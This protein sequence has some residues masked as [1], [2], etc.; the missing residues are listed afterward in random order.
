MI[1]LDFF[2]W[3]Y[4]AAPKKLLKIWGNFL[5]FF[6]LY[7]I[8]VPLL[9]KT[10]FAPWKRDIIRYGR[11]FEIKK[12]LEIFSLNIA[13]RVFG[14]VFRIFVIAFALL[15]ELVTVAG[16]F[17][18]IACWLFWPLILISSFVPA[19][20]FLF[21]PGLVKFSTLAIIIID[22]FLTSVVFVL[23][24][25]QLKKLPEQMSLA[26]IFK[27]PW[28]RIIWERIGFALEQMP[29]NVLDEPDKYLDDFLAGQSI[30]K[31]DFLYVLNW[32]LAGRSNEL[33]QKKFW[34]KEN[35]FIKGG[36]G[37]GWIY[38][39]TNNLDRFSVELGDLS[40][41]A[42]LIGRREEVE[43]MG[44]ILSKSQQSN[45]I[46]VGE[47]GVGKL[48]LVKQFARLVKQARTASP[49]VFRR[50]LELDL[51]AALSGLTS[52][53]Q[54]E[55]K[56]ITLFNEAASAGNVILVIDD[57]HNFLAPTKDISAILIPFIQGAY[58][59]LIAM[60]D[61]KNFHDT[62]EKNPGLLKFFEKLEI[63]EPDLPHAM[64]I[65]QDNLAGLESR[66]G[67]RITYQALKEIIKTTDQFVSDVPMPEKALDLMEETAIFV[68]ANTK[69]YFV[70]PR[71]V[72]LVVSQKTEIPVGEIIESEKEKLLN[73]EAFLHKRVVSQDLAIKEIASAMRRARMG[74][75]A[76]TR[77]M[78]SFLF[79]GPTGVGKT[80][81]AKALAEA[82]FGNETRMLRFDMSEY[83]GPTAIER[84][85]GSSQTQT[86]GILTTA[87]RENPFSLLLLDEIE[88]AD[89]NVLN[90]F[91]QVL[92]EGLL[93]D[94][95]GRKINFRNQ[96]IIAT[97][98][99]AAELIRESVQNNLD[100]SSQRQKILDWI[101][102]KGLFLPEFLN[103]FDGII[104]FHPLSKDDILKIAMLNLQG[105]ASRLNSQEI[106]FNANQ[107]LA[108][109]IAE[110]GF[111]PA[112]GARAMKRVIQDKVEDLIA[113]KML[114]G[115]IQKNM[116]F[117][118]KAEE[119]I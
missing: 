101:Q 96:I 4:F 55:E 100:L 42:H 116:P 72:D 8:P 16:G 33:K 64:L 53:G 105:L 5:Q 11:G 108:E 85:I 83:Q 58:F 49:L 37:R 48:T 62:V 19:I 109:K 98:N 107:G 89:A 61:Y 17:L 110:L 6:I 43:T 54:I 81:T 119:I 97:S 102:Q 95:L 71:H 39:W 46:L 10:L 23:Y 65:L 18:F 29:Q 117:E 73:L 28:S 70:L 80:E 25:R 113:K 87:V 75:A 88:K 77:P 41:T 13:S 92:D 74:V 50:V 47:P 52:A 115:E 82:Y 56:L 26:D 90:L 67:R 22:L 112:F 30:K 36:F 57:F 21:Q 76:K 78:G 104:L 3:Y 60:T 31:E 14:A 7:F 99:A 44:R 15:V 114:S 94:A 34:E 1:I 84:M 35:L 59:Q 27:E 79:L 12:Y 38:G 93:T 66:T 118:I 45:I 63:K 24:R 51:N 9:L 32:L 91:L 103:R 2:R 20:Y 69:D 40:Q 106:I 86:P 68:S 111:D